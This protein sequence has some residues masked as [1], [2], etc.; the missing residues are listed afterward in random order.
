MCRWTFSDCKE[1]R[2]FVLCAF[3]LHQYY[4]FCR[5]ASDD[6]GT[7]CDFEILKNDLEYR[8]RHDVI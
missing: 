6:T 4:F 5:C 8:L 1:F 3:A 2:D 7:F